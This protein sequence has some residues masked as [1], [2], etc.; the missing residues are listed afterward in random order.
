MADAPE[1]FDVLALLKRQG[2]VVYDLVGTAHRP[3]DGALAQ[4]DLLCVPAA[5][6]LRADHRWRASL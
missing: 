6:P 1:L 4:V 3:L 5:S 2:F